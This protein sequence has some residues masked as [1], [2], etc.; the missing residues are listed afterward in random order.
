M[1]RIL[2]VVAFPAVIT[3]I[4]G[5]GPQVLPKLDIRTVGDTIRVDEVRGAGLALIHINLRN[6]SPDSVVIDKCTPRLQRAQD[7]EWKTMQLQACATGLRLLWVVPPRDSVRIEYYLEDSR[8]M[9]VLLRRGPLVTGEYRLT[10]QGNWKSGNRWKFA[11]FQSTPS[12][13]ARLQ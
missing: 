6:P 9:R 7:N 8:K 3:A 2:F 1:I 13:L 4:A 10:F 5:C 12:K 11:N